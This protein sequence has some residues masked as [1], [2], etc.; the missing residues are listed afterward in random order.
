MDSLHGIVGVYLFDAD[1][2]IGVGGTEQAE[3]LGQGM[4][5][6]G[7]NG[8]NAQVSTH[9]RARSANVAGGRLG[10]REEQPTLVA[11]YRVPGGAPL[12]TIKDS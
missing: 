1:F 4:S 7:R 5:H 2:D 12:S 8:T 11:S 10:R 6:G 9:S 3:G